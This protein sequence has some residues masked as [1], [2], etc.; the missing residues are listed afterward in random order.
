MLLELE[1]VDCFYSD[2]QVVRDVSF[3]L[4]QG[5]VL[6][7]LGRN[8]AGKTTLLKS[9][10]GLVRKKGSVRF[11]GKAID[12]L[13]AYEIPKLGIGYVPQGR[14]LFSELSVRE[15]LLI[16]QMTR[17]KGD[18]VLEKVFDLFPV[19]LERLDQE[20]G[21]LSGGEQQML[22]MARAM[23]IEPGLLMLDEPTEGLM[24]QMISNIREVISK[25]KSQGVG[26]LLVE[27]RVEAVLSIADRVAFIEN[28]AIRETFEGRA[29]KQ[30]DSLLKRYVGI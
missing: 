11:E 30:D 7:L 18:H 21:T 5:E 15:N 25:L 19:L 22:A 2:L 23:C 29:L 14:R 27:Q 8:G 16:G 20:S 13:P 6:C 17:R 28:G 1:R 9:I 3:Q 4:R 12:R 26:I 10:V 24:P